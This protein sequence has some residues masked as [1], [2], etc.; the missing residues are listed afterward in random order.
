MICRLA[1][2][3]VNG[4]AREVGA[5]AEVATSRKDEKYAELDS[6]YLFR[7][8][9]VETLGVF[10]S[11]ANRLLKEIGLRISANTGESRR[12]VFYTSAFRC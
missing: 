11:S 2:S 3:Y 10:N 5:A 12:P 7:L 4:A 1:E 6:R 9:A 8:I